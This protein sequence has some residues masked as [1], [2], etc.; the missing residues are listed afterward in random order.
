VWLGAWGKKR[1]GEFLPDCEEALG[2]RNTVCEV[3]CIF[4]LIRDT[5]SMY[6]MVLADRYEFQSTALASLVSY[7]A[8]M[9]S[10]AYK[11]PIL[12]VYT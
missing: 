4:L 10:Q 9:K 12:R 7:R 8:I 3:A 5:V 6:L 11:V 2:E 1:E